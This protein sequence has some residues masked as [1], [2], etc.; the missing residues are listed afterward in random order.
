MIKSDSYHCQKVFVIF[1]DCAVWY[2][3]RFEY[4]RMAVVA[5]GEFGVGVGGIFQGFKETYDGKSG[6]YHNKT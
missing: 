1:I 6:G 3:T 4:L 2:C 5:V